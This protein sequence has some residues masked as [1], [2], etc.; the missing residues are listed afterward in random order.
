MLDCSNS[1]RA[2]S[3][4]QKRAPRMSHAMRGPPHYTSALSAACRSS[5]SSINRVIS[6]V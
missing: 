2:S 5:A 4:L 6:A 3:T 1:S